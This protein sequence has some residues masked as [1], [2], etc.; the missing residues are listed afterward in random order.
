MSSVS[1]WQGLI[2]QLRF[3]PVVSSG[4]TIEIDKIT[5]EPVQTVVPE[6]DFE[7][8]SYAEGWMP[9]IQL[10]DFNVSNGVL[11]MRS[12][13]NDPYL[14]SAPVQFSADENGQ[15]RITMKVSS[16]ESTVGQVFFTT[17]LDKDFNEAKSLVFDVISDGEFHTYDLDMS[18]V[19]GWRGL[20]TQ[21]R[22]DPVASE[23]RTIEIDRI[24]IEP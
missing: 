19:S 24:A 10:I 18:T 15:L 17:D 14:V 1:G 5:V 13:G 7:T 3:D 16:G 4:R 20:I 23:G 11:S 22:I 2:Q 6:W 21:I 8:D 9:Q 12:S